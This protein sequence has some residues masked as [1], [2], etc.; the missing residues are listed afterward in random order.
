MPKREQNSKVQPVPAPRPS[1]EQ[2]VA[3]AGP[4]AVTAGADDG[5]QVLLDDPAAVPGLNFD[6]YATALAGMVARSR[7][8]FAV[9]IFGGWGTGKT[10]LMRAIC[11]CLKDDESIVRVWFSA[12]RYEREPHLIV[13]LLDVLREALEVEA[14][15]PKKKAWARKA[16]SAVA[17]AGLAFLAGVT[18]SASFPG[19]EA[20]F[21]PGEMID[22]FKEDGEDTEKVPALSYYHAGFVL[23]KK[24]ISELSADGTRRVV[25]FVDDLDRCLPERALDVLESMKLFF[26]VE[27]CVFVVG[28]DQDIVERAVLTK[29]RRDVV[30][31]PGQAP[32]QVSGQEEE[33]APVSGIEYIKKIFQVP[34]AMPRLRDAQLQDYLASI[35]RNSGFGVVQLADFRDTVRPH[36]LKLQGSPQ[37]NLREIKRLINTY[38]L[39]LQILDVGAG[40]KPNPHVVLALLCMNFRDDWR[41]LYDQLATDPRLFQSAITKALGQGA[42]PSEEWIGGAKV[43]LPVNFVEYLRSIGN[44]LLTVPNL[45][46]Y[47][48]AAESS[49]TTE[50]WVL[51]A[52]IALGELRKAVE[53]AQGLLPGLGEAVSDDLTR[54]LTSLAFGVRDLDG[55]FAPRRRA[56]GMAGEISHRVDSAYRRLQARSPEPGTSVAT[57]SGQLRETASLLGELDAVLR[58]Y[59][60]TVS[61][62]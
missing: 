24:A 35:E 14:E 47:V 36:L 52:R 45:W 33:L 50:P 5:F 19:I 8:E 1:G 7:A 49:L 13:P 16:A 17:R 48:A 39:Q 55:L 61:V 12:W 3:Q 4:Q 34:F 37:V 25:I 28:L 40:H 54:A 46:V 11:R 27:G 59:S 26:D 57:L 6:R 32:G 62:Y 30:R 51:D 15:E 22:A 41:P 18:I 44:P 20:E 38:S 53:E 2:P 9:G 60:R 23:L 29:Y 43:G 42:W 21:E 31:V 58:E 10:T 56:T